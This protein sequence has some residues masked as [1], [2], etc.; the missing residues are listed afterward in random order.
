M[1]DIR[2]PPDK[3]TVLNIAGTYHWEE[4]HHI[5]TDREPPDKFMV[6]NNTDLSNHSQDKTCDSHMINTEADYYIPLIMIYDNH[7]FTCTTK[8]EPSSIVD[9]LP[10]DKIISS[11]ELFHLN[12]RVPPDKP[13]FIEIDSSSYNS[14][15]IAKDV[16]FISTLLRYGENHNLHLLPS[17]FP[18]TE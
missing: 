2:I 7:D 8:K 13:W 17:N 3:Y 11:S 4:I 9:K 6:L 10:P 18:F 15:T 1:L 14:S 16:Y 5:L 12:K